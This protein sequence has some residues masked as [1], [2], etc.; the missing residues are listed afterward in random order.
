MKNGEK[1]S[2]WGYAIVYRIPKMW[3]LSEGKIVEK[4]G[5]K[6]GRKAKK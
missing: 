3:E 4:E 2:A 6:E 1:L 5:R